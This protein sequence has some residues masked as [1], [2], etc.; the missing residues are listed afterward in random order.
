LNDR[1]RAVVNRCDH[2]C[3]IANTPRYLGHNSNLDRL[4][5]MVQ[6]LKVVHRLEASDTTE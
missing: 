4:A 2:S 5:Q 6:L 3:A 1:K